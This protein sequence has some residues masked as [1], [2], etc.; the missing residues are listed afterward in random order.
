MLELLP[1]QPLPFQEIP[2]V[3]LELASLPAQR[4]KAVLQV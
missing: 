4:S 2:G 3:W 1:G